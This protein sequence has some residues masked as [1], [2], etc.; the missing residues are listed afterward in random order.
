MD[1]RGG[2]LRRHLRRIRVDP[3]TGKTDWI[4][5][6]GTDGYVESVKSRSGTNVGAEPGEVQQADA[7][8]RKSQP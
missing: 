1:T 2:Q 7:Q 5:V 3:L 6:M 4:A 8:S